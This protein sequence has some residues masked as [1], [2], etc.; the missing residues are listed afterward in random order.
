MNEFL[1]SGNVAP[2]VFTGKRLADYSVVIDTVNP[3]ARNYD[4][5]V[6]ETDRELLQDFFEVIPVKTVK[7]KFE[8]ALIIEEAMGNIASQCVVRARTGDGGNGGPVRAAIGKEVPLWQEL[9]GFANN[10][11]RSVFGV[12]ARRKL[13][14]RTLNTMFENAMIAIT[15]TLICTITD[16]EGNIVYLEYIADQFDIGDMANAQTAREDPR[17][18][19]HLKDVSRARGFFSTGIVGGLAIIKAPDFKIVRE[20]P[21]L[22]FVVVSD[23]EPITDAVETHNELAFTNLPAVALGRVRDIRTTD[24]KFVEFSDSYRTFLGPIVHYAKLF[25]FGVSGTDIPDGEQVQFRMLTD[26]NAQ[27]S[28]DPFVVRAGSR[29]NIR[30]S[31]QDLQVV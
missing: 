17:H 4:E 8:T 30:R 10:L 23:S 1:P 25:T 7:D 19:Q 3:N 16:P 28:G 18:R 21:S 15:K 5:A 6:V 31:D 27:G 20:D 13:G 12:M 2:D 11:G 22:G 29:V 26:A 14:A 24:E 9:D